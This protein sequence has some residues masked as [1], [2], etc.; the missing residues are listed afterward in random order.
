MLLVMGAQALPIQARQDP[1]PV[2]C[3]W[4][5]EIPQLSLYKE[6]IVAFRVFD[7]P[8]DAWVGDTLNLIPVAPYFAICRRELRAFP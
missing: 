4:A 7:I 3:I 2:F 8:E 6:N 1:D 5:L